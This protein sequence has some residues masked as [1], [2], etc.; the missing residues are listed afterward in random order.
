MLAGISLEKALAGFRGK[1]R[2]TTGTD[3][4]KALDHFGIKHGKLK[5][6]NNPH[7]YGLGKIEWLM[8]GQHWV[9]YD[10]GT[11]YDP[12]NSEPRSIYRSRSNG[13]RFVS[14]MT[15]ERPGSGA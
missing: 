7:G 5:R 2:K 15:I 11:I 3:M 9:V 13:S 1:I 4:A 8:G 10:C 14:F 12:L 6:S